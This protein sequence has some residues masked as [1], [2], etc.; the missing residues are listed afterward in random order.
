MEFDSTNYLRKTPRYQCLFRLELKMKKMNEW[1]DKIK[2]IP[3]LRIN[4]H[5]VYI[6]LDASIDIMIDSKMDVW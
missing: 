6:S 4:T 5:T 3:A 1:T 2:D